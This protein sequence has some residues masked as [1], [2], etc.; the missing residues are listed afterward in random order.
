MGINPEL[1]LLPFRGVKMVAPSRWNSPQLVN[2]GARFPALSQ[3]ARL[4]DPGSHV[5]KG[6]WK[7]VQV[8]IPGSQHQTLL[9]RS[10]V[11]PVP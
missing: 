11:E 4:L 7:P 3:A 9:L 10:G 2:R 6:L 5:H 1:P 8:H